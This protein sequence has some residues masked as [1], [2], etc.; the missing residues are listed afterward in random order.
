[1][2]VVT[3]DASPRGQRADT[4]MT[5]YIA[6]TLDGTRLDNHGRG[7]VSRHAA[8]QAAERRGT[9]AIET[10]PIDQCLPAANDAQAWDDL[11]TANGHP[12]R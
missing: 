2:V 3:I 11:R 6:N 9:V 10:R 8:Q 1:M 12:A 5:T 7:Y 4:D